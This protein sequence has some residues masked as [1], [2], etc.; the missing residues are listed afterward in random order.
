MEPCLACRAQ[1]RGGLCGPSAH[2]ATQTSGLQRMQ[3]KE[4]RNWTAKAV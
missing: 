1:L 2:H 3:V 4:V